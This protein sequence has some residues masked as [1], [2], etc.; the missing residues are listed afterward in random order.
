MRAQPF[1]ER[2]RPVRIIALEKLVVQIVGIAAGADCT[3]SDDHA[4]ETCMPLRGRESRML[5]MEQHVQWMRR[6]NQMNQR[7]RKIKRMLDWMHRK[8]GPRPGIHVIVMQRM[9]PAIKRRP[10]NQAMNQIKVDIVK[11]RN[12]QQYREAID[13]VLSPAYIRHVTIRKRPQYTGFI[14]RP[15]RY[16]ASK[17]PD[18][19]VDVL[20]PEEKG[21]IVRRRPF[22]IEFETVALGL[23]DIQEEMPPPE[24]NQ[25]EGGVA[26]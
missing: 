9:N 17:S 6:H 15:D 12:E 11:R 4:I 10:M 7:S 13:R 20:T 23:P 22:P 2:N 14:R 3:T 21:V 8:A 1:I 26:K 25:N 18:D 19:V 24:N 5:Q 16:P